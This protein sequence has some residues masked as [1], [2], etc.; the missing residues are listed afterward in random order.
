MR[1]C[2]YGFSNPENTMES[3]SVCKLTQMH[4]TNCSAVAT[5]SNAT[6]S[7]LYREMEE[8]EEPFVHLFLVRHLCKLHKGFLNPILHISPL[9]ET[10]IP[11]GRTD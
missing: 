8:I 7:K 5:E 9:K 11:Y 10:T 6:I 3:L 2:E 1:K 4:H